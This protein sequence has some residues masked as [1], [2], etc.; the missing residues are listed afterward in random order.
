[1]ATCTQDKTIANAN[2]VATTTTLLNVVD[3]VAL[4]VS[5]ERKVSPVPKAHKAQRAPKV[6]KEFR[7]QLVQQVQQVRLAQQAQRAHKVR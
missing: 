5:R 6:P 4:V 2:V 3:C 1:M 7:D